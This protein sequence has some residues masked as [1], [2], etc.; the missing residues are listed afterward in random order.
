MA[1]TDE[2]ESPNG[3]RAY[4]S[5]QGRD[6][7]CRPAASFGGLNGYACQPPW[8][9]WRWRLKS[10]RVVFIIYFHSKQELFQQIFTDA[11]AAGQADSQAVLERDIPALAKIELM[12]DQWY[13][14]LGYHLRSARLGAGVTGR[15]PP[16]GTSGQLA[17]SFKQ[18]VQLLAR[19]FVPDHLQGHRRG[20]VCRRYEVTVA[21][22]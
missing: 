4:N 17:E 16:R 7:R 6:T 9:Q 19:E 2:V 12:L 8:R 14:Q 11:V 1:N 21:A 13:Q 22:T 10:L 18:D 5:A 15:R 20:R 3:Q